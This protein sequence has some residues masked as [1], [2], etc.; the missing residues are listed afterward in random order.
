MI[1]FHILDN[2]DIHKKLQA[3]LEEALPNKYDVVD[4]RIVEQLPYL[5]SLVSRQ[6]NK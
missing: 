5:V 3:E 1:Q 6:R 2:P 4:L